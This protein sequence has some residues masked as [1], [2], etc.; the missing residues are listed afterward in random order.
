MLEMAVPWDEHEEQQQLWNAVN[1]VL[2][3]R[4][5]AGLTD[6]AVAASA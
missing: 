2:K 1:Q 4:M 6:K 3:C 5:M